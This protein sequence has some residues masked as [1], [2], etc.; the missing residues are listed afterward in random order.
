MY[1]TRNFSRG[2]SVWATL[3]ALEV[4]G[5]VE[6]GV[7]SAPAL[8]G[9]WWAVRGEGA[10]TTGGARLRVSGVRELADAQLAHGG[11][12]DWASIGRA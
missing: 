2:L 1:G 9:R 3:I 10:Y 11:L 6:L 8:R 7:V 5:A 12:E 4:S